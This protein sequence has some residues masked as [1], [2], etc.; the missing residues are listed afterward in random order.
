[1]S[2][3]YPSVV[4][5]DITASLPA[6]NSD[7]SSGAP[8]LREPMMV[9]LHTG[10]NTGYAIEPLERAFLRMAQTLTQDDGMIHFAYRDLERGHPASLPADFPN[11]AALDIRSESPQTIA[12]IGDCIAQ[13]GI[14]TVFA[15]DAPVTLRSYGPMRR[16]GMR[17]LISYQGAPMSS[18]NRGLRLVAKRLEV[19]LR[20]SG[21][22][23]YIF[24]SE[25]MRR[26]AVSG[27]G[28]P[29]RNTSVVYL[30]AD[31]TKFVRRDD[32][33]AH[34]EF[35]IPE[36]RMLVVYSGHMEERKGVRVLLRAVVE[37]ASRGI[38]TIHLLVLG[39][40]AGEAETFASCYVGTPAENLI[41][42]G[43]YRRDIAAIFG[44]ADVGA[45]ASTG[46]D[47]FTMSA[48]EMAACELPLVVSDLQGLSETVDV[49]VT[50]FTFEPGNATMLADRLQMLE[51]NP[52][53]RSTMGK[54]A[55][56]RA[57]ERHSLEQQV[58][59]LAAVVHSAAYD[60]R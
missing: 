45:I 41:T 57:H 12:E 37:L 19:R 47:S 52:D 28:I 7:S 59:A 53:L 60:Q 33:Y 8:R 11:V 21:P 36:H 5:R 32:R 49:G 29:E 1:M 18:L 56:Q 50:G 48:V 46:W 6:P 20:T 51:S 40:Q 58:S 2:S 42:F 23:H 25:A 24:E 55:R 38:D 26:T 35:G 3:H 54:A 15:F 43:G 22:D 44:S 31:L 9:V 17:R 4:Q 27:R 13:H 10:S 30:G 16:A 39:N 14:R 34:R